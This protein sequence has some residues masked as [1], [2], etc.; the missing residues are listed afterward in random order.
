MDEG[1]EGAVATVRI[2]MV[3]FPGMTQ[4]DFTAPYEVFCRI[5]GAD[6][7]VVG[8]AVEP[9]R[10]EH[11]LVF[12]P[13]LDYAHAPDFDVVFVPGGT[14]VNALLED[15]ATLAFLRRQ[16]ASARYVTS[17]CTGALV[18]AA[19]GLLEGR[20]ATTHWLSLPLLAELGAVAVDDARVVFDGDR[21]TG[22]GVTAGIDFALALARELVGEAE[23]R[24]IQLM[25][26][27][28]PEPPFDSGTPSR[29][30][31]S[32]VRRV[33]AEREVAQTRRREIVARLVAARRAGGDRAR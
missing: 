15:E 5:P 29:A 3:I 27:Y 22:G 17:V 6:V 21:I 18:L 25:I 1:T 13:D 10:S 4:L 12:A 8:A 26:E 2:G 23:A 7:S 28:A 32:V 30:E 33:R 31:P 19:A 9:M 16:A 14:G 24:A 11:G 20:Q